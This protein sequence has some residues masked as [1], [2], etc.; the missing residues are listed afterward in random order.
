MAYHLQ[1]NGL[2]ERFHQSMKASL[3]ACSQSPSWISELP[4]VML[5]LRT[6]LKDDLGISPAELVFRSLLMVPGE[7][8]GHGQGEPVPELLHCLRDTVVDLRPVTPV[9]HTSP[10]TSSLTSLFS[11]KFIFIHHDGHRSPLQ[12]CYDGPFCVLAPGDIFFKVQ[13]GHHEE[14]ISMDRLKITN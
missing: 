14:T 9:H 1:A 3:R 4:W 11:A 2:V 10:T 13:V 7:F 5:G 8:V 12:L 6:M